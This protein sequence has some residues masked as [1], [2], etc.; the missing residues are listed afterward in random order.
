MKDENKH[1]AIAMGLKNFRA[2]YHRKEFEEKKVTK[3]TMSYR[4]SGEFQ[5]LGIKYY[6]RKYRK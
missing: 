4:K 3:L 6:K 5:T 1:P 2:C